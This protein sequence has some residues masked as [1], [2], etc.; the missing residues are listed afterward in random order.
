MY[1]QQY[2][3][4][5]RLKYAFIIL[6]KI[7]Y[8]IY[9]L[10]IQFFVYALSF[11]TETS[12]FIYQ[13][14]IYLCFAHFKTCLF[15]FKLRYINTRRKFARFQ[16]FKRVFFDFGII[17]ITIQ[18]LPSLFKFQLN[19]KVLNL[20]ISTPLLFNLFFFLSLLYIQQ[21]R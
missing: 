1:Y 14:F 6:R 16:L 21:W 15:L 12:Y 2:T 5:E 7:V 10:I 11:Y 20:K 9:K 17:F 3:R 19:L 8:K 13:A 18:K 4:Q